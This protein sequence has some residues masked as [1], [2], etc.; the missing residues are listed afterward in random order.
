M[1]AARTLRRKLDYQLLRWQARLDGEWADRV[2]PLLAAA[3]LFVVLAALSLAQA[4]TF[5]T[6]IELG[7]WIQG[8]WSI[9]NGQGADTTL[10]GGNLFEPQGAWAFWL[11]AQISRLVPPAP[12]LIVMQS[13]GLA[14]GV[15]PI[16]RLCRKV[17][18]LRVGAAVGAVVAY[19]LHPW[20]HTLNLA[21]FHPEALAVPLLL[22]TA[23]AGLRRRWVLM[24]IW[25]VAAMALRSDLGFTVA[26]IGVLVMLDTRARPAQ[27][28]VW[29]GLGWGLLSML[30]LQPMVGDGSFVHA[31]ALADYGDTLHGAV[32]GMITD[33]LGVLGDL[34][35]RENF[36]LVVALGAPI[37]FLPLLCPRYLVPVVP[38][39]TLILVADVPV[40][41]AE[42]SAN[43]IPVMVFAFVALPFAL[44]RIGRRNIERI[45]VDRRVLSA[46]GLAAVVFFIHEAP[47]SPYEGPWAWG[48]R[49]LVD[50]VRADAVALVPDDTAVRSSPS[51]VAALAERQDLYA[52]DDDPAANALTLTR[53]VDAVLVDGTFGESWNR[54]RRNGVLSAVENQGFERVFDDQDVTLFVRD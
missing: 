17:C 8:A 5:D 14:L 28:L 43:V 21:D 46:L 13:L 36:T 19:G 7:R 40:L 4:R 50:R 15:I 29:L 37:A 27:R 9:T 31:S 47:S 30:V 41:G 52:I 3:G 42:G 53:G 20:L 35:A 54:A 51:M 22:A 18:S 23:Y 34:L 26:A 16:W 1:T 49:S 38:V 39:V 12:L 11:I 44:A 45:T 6:G 10:A 2:L 32:W 24:L 48:G 33:P 25:A